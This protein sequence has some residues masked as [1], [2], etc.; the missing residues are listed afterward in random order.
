MWDPA[1]VIVDAAQNVYISDSQ[2]SAIRKV[3]SSTGKISTVV[4][5]GKSLS[6]TPPNLSAVVLYGPIGLALDGN[7]NLYIADYFNMRIRELQSNVSV[8]DYTAHPT[9]QGDTS[10]EQDQKLEN[11]GTYTLSL[12]AIT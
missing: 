8:L 12:T 7:G 1:G 10:A 5:S 9:R 3:S 11:Y 4:P 6:G 2:N